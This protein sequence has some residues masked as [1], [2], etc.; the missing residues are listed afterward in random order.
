VEQRCL[1]LLEFG[2]ALLGFSDACKR[3]SN[4]RAGARSKQR[5]ICGVR[6]RSC[7]ASLIDRRCMV[8]SRE[9]HGRGGTQG[10]GSPPRQ[11]RH[12]RTHLGPVCGLGRGLQLTKRKLG[13]DQ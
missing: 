13:Q 10:R 4:Q 7:L 9:K 11:G 3:C 2:N 8:P 1:G 6:Q 5:I 12:P